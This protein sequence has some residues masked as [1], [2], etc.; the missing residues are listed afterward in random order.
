MYLGGFFSLNQ[1]T[2]YF[3]T[4]FRG[5]KITPYSGIDSRYL[6]NYVYTDRK[7]A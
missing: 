7:E 2:R 5:F 4:M 1:L 6:M 3:N